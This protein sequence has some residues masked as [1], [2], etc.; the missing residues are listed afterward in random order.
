MKKIGILGG[1]SPESTIEYYRILNAEPRKNQDNEDYPEII[2]YSVNL[3]EFGR[4]MESGTEA[5]AIDFLSK[6]INSLA[7][8][9]ANFG[10]IA[11]NTPHKFFDE[12]KS[13]S[14]IPLIS[15]IEATAE[16][17]EAENYRRM[18]I[19]GTKYTMED[20]LYDEELIERDIETFIPEPKERKYVHEKIVK[21]LTRGKILEETKRKIIEIIDKMER[22][23]NIDSVI[24]AC[25]ELPLLLNQSD[26]AL[27]LLNTTEI[28]A[29]NA[30]EHASKNNSKIRTA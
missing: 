17:A 7:Q 11:S 21:E 10:L 12:V 1:L 14:P 9:G 26:L 18:G 29:K 19:L 6:G 30:L 5:E 4:I 15:I 28:H 3:A 2:I 27:P 24:L 16:V 20:G 25:T 13:R 8:A 23:K 22:E